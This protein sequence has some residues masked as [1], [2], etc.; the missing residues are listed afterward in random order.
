MKKLFFILGIGLL[1]SCVSNKTMVLY[2]GNG[3]CYPSLDNITEMY[4]KRTNTG[5]DY[6]WFNCEWIT[7]SERDSLE[8]VEFNLIW[9]RVVDSYDTTNN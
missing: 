6:V 9:D 1:T 3:D 5:Q 2:D 4:M 7:R 8:L